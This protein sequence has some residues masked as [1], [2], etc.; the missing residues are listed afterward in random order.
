[1]NSTYMPLYAL[2]EEAKIWVI[3]DMQTNQILVRKEIDPEVEEIYKRLMGVKCKNVVLVKDVVR[4]RDRC[5][6]IE[7]Y[8][9]GT[10]LSYAM[11]GLS[12]Q[13][14][15]DYTKDILNGLSA[16]HGKDIVHRDVTPNNIV[17]DT[18]GS[19]HLIDFGISRINKPDRSEDTT[20][21]G[22]PGYAAPEQF[23]FHQTDMRADLYG[24]G[25]ILNKMLSQCDFHNATRK[26]KNEIKRLNRIAQKAVSMDP[27]DRYKSAKEM[28]L[29]VEGKAA[30]DI[31]IVPG[32]RSGN[33][34]KG[35]IAV[36]YYTMAAFLTYIISFFKMTN[37]FMSIRLLVFGILLFFAVPLVLLNIFRWDEKLWFFPKLSKEL[38]VIARFIV[39]LLIALIS[40]YV[41]VPTA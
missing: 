38:R 20:I 14:I 32:F 35:V 13:Q 5:F 41:F 12:I 30:D 15:T 7:E 24:V 26:E 10:T 39:A 27:K 18:W 9:S 33:A 21:L 2:D 28:L 37:I 36:V 19:C 6:S 11:N 25:I 3:R 4:E 34:L 22:T 29:V 8:I 31:S 40:I 16:A 17:V 23:G 1:M